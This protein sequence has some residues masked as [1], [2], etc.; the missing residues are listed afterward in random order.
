V[1]LEESDRSPVLANGRELPC[2]AFVQCRCWAR[3]SRP[4]RRGRLLILRRLRSGL[5]D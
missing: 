4:G 5:C 3:L 1:P 2:E